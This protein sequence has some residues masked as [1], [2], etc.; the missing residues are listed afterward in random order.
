M[1][2]YHFGHKQNYLK[3]TPI[4]IFLI[5]RSYPKT[6]TI[7]GMW[8]LIQPRYGWKPLVTQLGIDLSTEPM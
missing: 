6:S 5:L 8:V 7:V 1:D 3:K 4:G 2:D